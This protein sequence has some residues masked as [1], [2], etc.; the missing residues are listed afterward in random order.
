MKKKKSTIILGTM[1][2][3]EIFVR[4]HSGFNS[5]KTFIKNSEPIVNRLKSRKY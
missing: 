2:I 1:Q 3:I 5:D 4:R